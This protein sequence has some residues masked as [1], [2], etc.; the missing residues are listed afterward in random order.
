MW[1]KDDRYV[2]GVGLSGP[3]SGG[4][5]YKMSTITHISLNCLKQLSLCPQKFITAKGSKKGY[6]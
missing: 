1:G 6:A 3:E 2:A 5:E 4:V